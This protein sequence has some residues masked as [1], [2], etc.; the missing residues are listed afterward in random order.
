V[1]HSK[2]PVMGRL[3]D[4][5]VLSVDD[6]VPFYPGTTAIAESPRRRGLL[7]VGTDD[8]KFRISRDDGKTFESA[9]SRFPGLPPSSWF[10]G[11]EASRHADE[12][13]YV[14][15]DN[16]RS[17]DFRNYVYK[18]TDAGRTFTSIVGN[19]PAD[20]VAR[21]VREDPRN[22]NLLYLGTE[23]GLFI[24][25]DGGGRWVELKNNMP[26]LAFNDLTIQTR[27]ND[28]V[29][30][31]HGRGIWILDQLT[32]LQGLTPAVLSAD[33][34]L[35]PIEPAEQIRYT[36]LKAHAGDM[37]FRGEN[38]PAGAIIDFWV[39]KT[40]TSVSLTVHDGAGQ[41]V[42]TIP[43]TAGRGVMRGV[44]RVVWNLRHAPLPVRGG[45]FGDDDGPGGATT[46]GPWVM[47]G[48]YTVRLAAGGRTLEQKVDVRDD[49]RIDASPADRKAWHDFV[50]RVAGVI[51]TYAPVADKVRK[52][53]AGDAA[54][55]DL[56]RQAQE[57]QSRL[58]GLYGAAGRFVGRPTA[59][60]QSRLKYYE[61]M[62]AKITAAAAGL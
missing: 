43:P 57:L 21:T 9:E 32:A 33:A 16:H 18:S 3:P 36:N 38:P 31:T 1:D 51:R 41:L 15:V 56:K 55:T 10:G 52:A 11:I 54:R 28:L 50:M 45:G 23:I 6:G 60:Q 49:P 48:T 13:L 17:N 40:D 42:Q 22:P 19:L 27:D 24:T 2:L 30:A 62:V 20:R 44:N 59:D 5:N 14:V 25:V 53:P 35:F 37:I 47:P 61:E 12:T 7:Y 39:A 46:P 26:T 29:L 4:E 8:G 58:T 34:H